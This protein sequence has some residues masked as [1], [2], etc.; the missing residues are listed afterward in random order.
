M[1]K[2]MALLREKGKMAKDEWENNDWHSSSFV[3]CVWKN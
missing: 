3:Q 2:F 1:K